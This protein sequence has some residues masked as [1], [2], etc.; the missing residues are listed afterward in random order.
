MLG[1]QDRPPPNSYVLLWTSWSKTCSD[2]RSLQNKL[3]DMEL[4]VGAA[5]SNMIAQVVA[6][7]PSL[8]EITP[9]KIPPVQHTHTECTKVN[10]DCKECVKKSDTH[11]IRDKSKIKLKCEQKH[12]PTIPPTSNRVERSPAFLASRW[13]ETHTQTHKYKHTHLLFFSAQPLVWHLPV[14][15]KTALYW[16]RQQALY[17][18]ADQ[19]RCR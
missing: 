10:T 18:L 11:R 17:R 12:L 14:G 1:W 16:D 6:L 7:F 8:S 15:N 4:T 3:S 9:A 19:S 2:F 5:S 13:A